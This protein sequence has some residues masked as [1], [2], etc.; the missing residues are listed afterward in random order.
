MCDSSCAECTHACGA[1]L[2]SPQLCTYISTPSSHRAQAPP[3]RASV[4]TVHTLNHEEYIGARHVTFCH[5]RPAPFSA[6]LTFGKALS[7]PPPHFHIHGETGA[8]PPV[9]AKANGH[10]I[11]IFSQ[12]QTD[13]KG[14]ACSSATQTK[15]LPPPYVFAHL[16]GA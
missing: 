9:V 7:S 6:H 13:V 12:G 10:P 11:A 15:S 14:T 1:L 2:P 16:P 4:N 5:E 8:T 3:P